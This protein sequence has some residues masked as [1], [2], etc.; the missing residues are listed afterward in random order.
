[1]L[2]GS[3]TDEG[4]GCPD[5]TGVRGG[6][7]TDGNV[8]DESHFQPKWGGNSPR[9]HT[10]RGSLRVGS[11]EWCLFLGVGS[12]VKGRDIDREGFLSKV[13]LQRGPRVV[14]NLGHRSRGSSG[15]NWLTSGRGD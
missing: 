8:D 1:M 5:R 6:P 2:S 14:L 4:L 10:K 15:R 9:I 13:R 11:P 3:R 7:S 12:G